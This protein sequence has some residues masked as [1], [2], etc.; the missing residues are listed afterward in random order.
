MEYMSQPLL[1]PA[2][3]GLP[4]SRGV[5][6]LAR[7]GESFFVGQSASLKR[8]ATAYSQSA[9]LS[10]SASAVQLSVV[11]PEVMPA[12]PLEV[13]TPLVE[14]TRPLD[15]ARF[16]GLVSE[17]RKYG[18]GLMA[19]GLRALLARSSPEVAAG[20]ACAWEDLLTA[21]YAWPVWDV[22]YVLEEGCSDDAFE[23]FRAWV[24]TLGRDA[25]EQCLA[26]PVAWAMALP[27]GS[28]VE[29]GAEDD[30]ERTS[31]APFE[32]YERLTG[33]RLARRWPSRGGEP[34]GQRVPED[35]IMGYYEELVARRKCR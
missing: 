30:A 27:L 22:A 33:E 34:G 2:A 18:P 25:V 23:Y 13:A 21:L 15:P 32:A 20:F 24:V 12:R 19:G 6:V 35:Q 14:N 11:H 16:W 7:D 29:E 17:A 1:P 4:D 8:R 26:D 9:W 31:Y 10:S 28:L 5:Y 3:R